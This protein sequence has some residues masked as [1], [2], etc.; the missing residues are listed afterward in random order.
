MKVSV[1]VGGVELT[2]SGVELTVA[3]VRGLMRSAASIAIA[4]PREPDMTLEPERGNPIGFTASVDL[5]PER[6]SP[7]SVPWYDDE[8]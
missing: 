2:L 7:P 3:Q 1:V 5:D 6:H 8:E 4:L